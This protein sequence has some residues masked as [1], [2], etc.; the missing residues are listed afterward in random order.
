MD[1]MGTPVVGGAILI[2]R[3]SRLGDAVASHR[4]CATTPAMTMTPMHAMKRRFPGSLFALC[5]IAGLLSPE[6]GYAN[7]YRLG[8]LRI[9]HPWTTATPPGAPVGAGYMKITND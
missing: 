8:A 1:G 3:V 6:A 7:D 4:C 2:T 9:D 5:M